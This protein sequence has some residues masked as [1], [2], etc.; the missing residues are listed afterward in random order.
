MAGHQIYAYQKYNLL[1]QATIDCNVSPSEKPP[2]I[3]PVTKKGSGNVR[4]YGSYNGALDA[5]YDL[6]IKDTALE[7]PFISAPTFKGA[8]TAKISGISA[9]D[10]EAQGIQVLCLSTGTDTTH[11]QIEIEGQPFRAK[12]AGTPGNAIYIIIDDSLLTFTPTDYSLIKALKAGDTALTG[13][14]LD[15]DTKVLQGDKVPADA[16]RIA[17]GLDRVNIHLQYKK[18]EDGVWTYYFIMP[19]RQDV[20]AKTQVFFVTGGRRMTVTNGVITEQYTNIVTIADFWQQ[21]KSNSALIEPMN[22]SIETTRAITS[23]AVREIATKTDA[24][25]LPPYKDTS[26]SEYA[27]VLDAITINNAAL[28][29]LIEIKCINNDYVGEEIWDA[30]GSSSGDMGQAKTG[31]LANFGRLAFLI[32]QKFPKNWGVENKAWSHKVSY[33]DR[34]ENETAP[35]ICFKMRLGINSVAQTLILEYKQKPAA[36]SCPEA[37]FSDKCLGYEETGGGEITMA[38]YT[39]PD[40]LFW[41]DAQIDVKKEAA[42]LGVNQPDVFEG[43]AGAVNASPASMTFLNTFEGA[44]REYV[45]NFKALAQRIINLPEDNPSQLQSMVDS[46]KTLVGSLAVNSGVASVPTYYI[47]EITYNTEIYLA[48]VDSVLLYERTYG[49]KKNIVSAPGSCYID[50]GD[51]L[52]WE[53]RGLKAYLPAFTDTPYYSTVKVGEEFS[54]TKEFAI[55]ILIPCGGSLKVGDKIEVTIGGSAVERTYQLGDITYLPTIAHQNLFLIGGIDGD[56]L[57]RLSVKGEINSFPD[58]LLDRNAPSEYYHPKLRFRMEDGII[59]MQV[60]D[61]FDFAV[62]GGHFIW[63][64]N[65]GA[66]SSPIAIAPEIQTF[67]SG[68]QIGFDFGVSPSFSVGDR[69]EILCSQEFQAA[70][71]VTPWRQVRKGTG[72]ITFSFAAAVTI[73]CLIID[74]HTL[75]GTVRFKASNLADFSGTLIHNEIITVSALICKLY[76]TA[77]IT[78][79]YFRIEPGSTEVEIGH[80]FLGTVMQLALDADSI[81]PVKRYNIDRNEA[82][83]P[84]SLFK[85]KSN[86]Y[87]VAHKSFIRNPDWGKLAEFIE[88]VKTNGDM[89]FYFVPNFN[90]TGDCIRGSLYM[91][92]IEPESPVDM[93]AQPDDRIYRITMT[94]R[95]RE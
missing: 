73:N 60:G 50:A 74:R 15:W 16:H 89:P 14:E 78:A 69:W 86:G 9:S 71:M 18:F 37:N 2:L 79:K 1:P 12:T 49:L 10:L 93:N 62:E 46:Y 82:K 35:P 64:K 81:K 54:N 11:A 52:Y 38:I 63:R 22:S 59:P 75:S 25:F 53:V 26:A 6:M 24:Y 51:D 17:F 68:L 30:R 3:Y 47:Y 45:A 28:T 7:T 5:T 61:V 34:A 95:S 23:P 44:M 72:N 21:V 88:Y 66:W 4:L 85:Y 36:C 19:L 27:G 33:A 84:F 67:D 39:V 80:V 58:Y 76:L 91:D 20:S 40:L 42:W 92:S 70:N 55:L 32:P 65:S 41:T 57:Y 31:Q 8:G 77:A 90:Y 29:E 56:D 13:Q 94:I 83:E 48:L 87:E 43:R